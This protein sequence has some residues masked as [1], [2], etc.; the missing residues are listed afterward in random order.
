MQPAIETVPFQFLRFDEER[1]DMHVFGRVSDAPFHSF[2]D[3]EVTQR[4]A[5]ERMEKEET[6]WFEDPRGFGDQE[7]R[8]FDM[9]KYIESANRVEAFSREGER[10]GAG[11]LVI[12]LAG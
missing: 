9:F 10:I 7:P 11:P 5:I 4:I 8:I 3:D 2:N 12:D 6:A 1:I